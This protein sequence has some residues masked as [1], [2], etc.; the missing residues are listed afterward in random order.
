MT[1]DDVIQLLN[2]RSQKPLNTLQVKVLRS[3]WDGLTY[4]DMGREL[5]YQDAYIK[6]VASQLWQDLSFIVEETITKN[7]F[8]LKFNLLLANDY[9]PRGEGI[10]TS[11]TPASLVTGSL[12][13][14]LNAPADNSHWTQ[15]PGLL[16]TFPGSPIALQSPFYIERPPI[17]SSAYREVHQPGS[18][19]CIQAPPKTGKSSLLIRI[20]EQGREANYAIAMINFNA[21]DQA[22]LQDLDQFLRW[23]CANVSLQLN[24]PSLV[25]EHWDEILGSKVNCTLYFQDYLLTQL[26]KPLILAF[27]ETH[28]LLENFSVMQ[29]FMSLLR[30][31]HE[32]SKLDSLWENFRLIV[33][34]SI[35]RFVTF[36]PNHSPFNVGLPL[37]LPVFT[38]AQMQILATRYGFHWQNPEGVQKIQTLMKLTG[39]H[40]Y[41]SS[42]AFHYL[43]LQQ[44]TWEELA[45]LHPRVLNLYQDYLANY[46]R[47]LQDNLPLWELFT[48][49]LTQEAIATDNATLISQLQQL[50][51][52]VVRQQIPQCSCELYRRYFLTYC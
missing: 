50:G 11:L 1:I 7:N 33:V 35:K 15:Y 49:I 34:Y 29:D 30:F 21:V 19:I 3:A 26:G 22:T 42:L 43:L 38:E 13:D 10:P 45:A 4:A 46:Q 6:N 17:E 40:P 27:N 2:I 39:G 48:K 47:I 20:L 52:V 32:Q 28:R 23:L 51:L 44:I 16:Q 12:D 31:W 5:H 25:E 24:L 9:F 8:R 41:L 37:T 36:D 14:R 18:V